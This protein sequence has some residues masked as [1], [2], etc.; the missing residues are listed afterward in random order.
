MSSILSGQIPCLPISEIGLVTITSTLLYRVCSFEILTGSHHADLYTNFGDKMGRSVQV[1]DD[2]LKR[3]MDEADS[4]L[5]PDPTLALVKSLLNSIFY[6]LYAS[7]PL[8][9]MKKLLWSPAVLDSPEQISRLSYEETSPELHKA[10][11]RAADQLRFDCRLGLKYLRKMAPVRFGP[12][13]AISA[14]EGGM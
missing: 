2:V 11:F 7:S 10:L 13:S 12:E 8:A 3:R 5:T 6:H 14:Y 1:L 4:G 9:T